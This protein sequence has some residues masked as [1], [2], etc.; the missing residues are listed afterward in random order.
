MSPNVKQRRIAMNKANVSKAKTSKAKTRKPAAG[1]AKVSKAS[2]SK[3]AARKRTVSDEQ[4]LA[5]LVEEMI[6]NGANTAED[7][8]R[9]V[10]DLPLK[11]LENLGLES[12]ANK[13]RKVQDS[14]IGA[15]YELIHEINRQVAGLARDLLKQRKRMEK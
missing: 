6:D 9:E 10:M 8:H 2:T 14:S 11:V 3:P 4:Q 7:I 12:A 5:R 13:V 15:L 1:K